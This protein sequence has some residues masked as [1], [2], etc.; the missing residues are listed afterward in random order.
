MKRLL[1]ALVLVGSLG[2]STARA[3]EPRVLETVVLADKVAAQ[4]V[5]SAARAAGFTQTRVLTRYS[6]GHGWVSSVLVEGVAA[7]RAAQQAEKLA[8]IAGVHV[9]IFRPDGG[10]LVLEGEARGVAGAPAPPP[11]QGTRGS[12]SVAELLARAEVAHG[13][14]G[15][16]ARALARAGAVH[17]VFT[18]T[19]PIEGKP[20]T[21]RHDYWRDADGR[22]LGVETNGAGIDSVAVVGPAGAWLKSGGTVRM[23]DIGIL[24]ASIDDFAPEVIV[25]LALDAPSLLQS[26]ELERFKQLEGAESGVR[27]GQ[28]GDESEVGLS[29]LDLDPTTGRMLR[30]RYVT[31]AGPILVEMSGWKEPSAGVVVPGEVRIE[32]ADGA[33]ETL[34][35]E[36][37]ELLDAVPAGTF[38]KPV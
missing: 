16:G 19:V 24:V 27:L 21:V 31:E 37:L 25:T 26:L 28:G 2:L 30:A 22:R 15:G 17:F 10:R 13:G 36:R 20:R 3:T 32:R 38:N 11:V 4:R 7:D 34:K 29:F 8:G 18:R 14:R 6:I 9:Q 23:R 35:V 33:V 5:E 12:G 1:L